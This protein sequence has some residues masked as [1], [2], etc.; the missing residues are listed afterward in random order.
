MLNVNDVGGWRSGLREGYGVQRWTNGA[1]YEGQW[2][3][4]KAN[5]KGK[6]TH[7]HGDIYEGD[8]VDDKVPHLS[9]Q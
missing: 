7:F 5:G 8:W 6:Y 3:H 2:S 4:G 9:A 1:K